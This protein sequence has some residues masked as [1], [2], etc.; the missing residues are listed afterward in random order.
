MRGSHSQI[1]IQCGCLVPNVTL[2]NPTQTAPLRAIHQTRPT[3]VAVPLFTAFPISYMHIL[4][5]S[6]AM[7]IDAAARFH[8]PFP[9]TPTLTEIHLIDSC[10]VLYGSLFGKRFPIVD[11]TSLHSLVSLFFLFSFSAL[12]LNDQARAS[13]GP[14]PHQVKRV[15]AFRW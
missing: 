9:P 7:Y 4:K 11:V 1:P 2:P 3:L 6:H 12:D 8:T 10:V 15:A 14:C 5:L 13:Q